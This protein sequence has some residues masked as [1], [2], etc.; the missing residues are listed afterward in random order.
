LTIA[1]TAVRGVSGRIRGPYQAAQEEREPA[2][3]RLGVEHRHEVVLDEAG[4]VGLAA[5]R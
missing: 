1:T 4:V 5:R 3:E 2:R